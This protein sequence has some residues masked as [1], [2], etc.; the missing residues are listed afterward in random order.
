MIFRFIDVPQAVPISYYEEAI[1]QLVEKIKMFNGLLGI[2]QF[3]NVTTPGISDIDLLAV[4]ENDV[5]CNQNPFEGFPKKYKSLFT[6]G[7]D[8]MSLDFY[9]LTPNFTFWFNSKLIY[10]DP[11]KLTVKLNRTENEEKSLKVQ[12][13]VEFLIT[14]YIDLSLQIEYGI[15]KLRAFLQHLK[16]LMYDLEFL[17]ID[18][19]KLF[20]AIIE[21]RQWI[22]G[23][24]T[25]R[26]SN[27]HL[28]EWI[29]KFYNEYTIFIK[30][31]LVANKVYLPYQKSYFYRKN[32]VI[33]PGNFIGYKK[34][35]I[36]LPCFLAILG[37]K[38]FYNF[39][40]RLHKW[41]FTV[42]ITHKSN[43]KII[44]DR[45]DYFEKMRKYNKIYFQNFDTLTTGF[46]FNWN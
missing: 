17:G 2:I 23:W 7:I 3:G 6:H 19:G 9:Q 28:S 30:Q 46:S 42:P 31:Q 14:N 8:A 4:F 40:H 24:H 16:G 5:A 21:L 36:S 41:T 44:I 45:F 10:G 18:K 33:E 11:L 13:A 35:G 37:E 43:S 38:K 25:F 32:V 1:N 15:I 39:Q 26:P 12:T 22:K 27:A 29:F 34:N 20:D